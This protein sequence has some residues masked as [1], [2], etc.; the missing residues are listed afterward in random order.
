MMPERSNLAAS[1]LLSVGLALLTILVQ[2][3]ALGGASLRGNR[4]DAPPSGVTGRIVRAHAS[5]NA[6]LF[7]LCSACPNRFP[8]AGFQ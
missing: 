8:D 4:N 3:S 2:N 5:L 6:S 7:A 1:A